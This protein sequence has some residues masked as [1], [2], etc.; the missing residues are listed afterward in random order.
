MLCPRMMR[1]GGTWGITPHASGAVSAM[2]L[3]VP[4]AQCAGM[5]AQQSSP[6]SLAN[7]T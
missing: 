6:M 7:S 1:A 3:A 2:Y 4:A 5:H